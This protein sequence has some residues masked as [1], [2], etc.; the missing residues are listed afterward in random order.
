[1]NGANYREIQSVP[2]DSNII[3]RSSTNALWR[4]D[5]ESD[6]PHAELIYPEPVARFQVG[7]EGQVLI[8]RFGQTEYQMIDTEGQ[9]LQ[10]HID[11]L[12]GFFAYPDTRILQ[13][14]W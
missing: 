9:L 12:G 2:L 7:R 11:K 1:L 8:Q 3:M 5:V 10:E 13:F 14:D 4:I 6:E